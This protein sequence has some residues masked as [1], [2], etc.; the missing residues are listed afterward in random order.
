MAIQQIFSVLMSLP[1][2]PITQV[3]IFQLDR[4][5]ETCTEPVCNYVL[6]KG[7]SYL[8]ADNEETDAELIKCS[9]T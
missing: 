5:V 2:R 4:P 7:Y 9:C 3:A 1:R 8:K 6:G